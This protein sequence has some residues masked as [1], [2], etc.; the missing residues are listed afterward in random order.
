RTFRRCCR[1][2]EQP[3]R[4]ASFCRGE[5]P[6]PEREARRGLASVQLRRKFTSR[7]VAGW[8]IGRYACPRNSEPLVKTRDLAR[9]R[10]WLATDKARLWRQT[11]AQERW[12][13][14]G[15]A[16]T[17]HSMRRNGQ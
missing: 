3:E 9:S 8:V 2:C 15:Y 17:R 13:D 7:R 1:V 6:G 16:S 14:G 5:R 12:E 10:S 4:S 11:P